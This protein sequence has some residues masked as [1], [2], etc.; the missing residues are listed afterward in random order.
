MQSP[1]IFNFYEVARFNKNKAARRY[2]PYKIW[3]HKKQ[4]SLDVENLT[5][6]Q[7]HIGKSFQ[8]YFET[9]SLLP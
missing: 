3:G 1:F 6:S 8:F 5:A 4:G 9:A 2:T 7:P